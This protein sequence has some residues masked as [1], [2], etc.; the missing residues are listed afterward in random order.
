MRGKAVYFCFTIF[1]LLIIAAGCSNNND[2]SK[3]VFRYKDSVVGDNSAV[4][5]IITQLPF[6]EYYQEFALETKEEP[7]GIVLKY[8]T[9]AESPALNDENMKE[10]ALCNSAYL[11]SLVKNVEW[12]Q[13]DFGKQKLRVDKKELQEWY[14]EELSSMTNETDL[15]KLLQERLSD[16]NQ[17]TQY[18]EK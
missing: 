1:L 9:E 18:F 12:V 5:A 16:K 17:I 6:N 14:G 7:Y 10:L 15:K 8:D 11:F 4:G 2:S 13:Y 3:D